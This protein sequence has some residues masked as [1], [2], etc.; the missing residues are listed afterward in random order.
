MLGDLQTGRSRFR[1]ACFD[2]DQ[3]MATNWQSLSADSPYRTALAIRQALR[4]GDA[5]DAAAGLEELIEAMSRSDK[6]ALKSQLIRLMM[7][8]IKWRSQPERRSLSWAASIAN[9]RDEIADIR[10]ETPSL[11][12]AIIQGL[13]DKAFAAAL[14]QAEAEMQ[15]RSKVDA[16]A[17]DEVFEAEYR[18]DRAEPSSD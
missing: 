17:W 3:P 14:R 5:V 13:W 6:R 8:I 4:E 18:L 10:E 7:H 16:L 11:N 12:E 9:A 15:R 2:E 1:A